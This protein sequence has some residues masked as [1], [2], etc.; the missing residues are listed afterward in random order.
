MFGFEAFEERGEGDGVEEE[1]EDRA[2]QEGVGV[3]SVD[4]VGRFR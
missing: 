2:V 3:E 4:C 1:V